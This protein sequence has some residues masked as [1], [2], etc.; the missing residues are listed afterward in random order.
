MKIY[1]ISKGATFKY[2]PRERIRAAKVSA[3]SKGLHNLLHSWHKESELRQP[4]CGTEI[5]MNLNK[6]CV[7][8]YD[9]MHAMCH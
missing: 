3:V 9:P 6:S 2:S 7:V 4:Q 8:K 1:E 5:T